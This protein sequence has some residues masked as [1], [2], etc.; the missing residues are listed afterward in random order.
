[1]LGLEREHGCKDKYTTVA[2]Y[3][4]KII[5]IHIWFHFTHIWHVWWNSG[6]ITSK[7]GL[8]NQKQDIWL[9]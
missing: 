4:L 2:I 7:A 5:I 6:T 1:M 3:F 8:S 9:H